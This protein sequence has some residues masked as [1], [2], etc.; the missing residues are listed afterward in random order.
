MTIGSRA[1]V[2]SPSAALIAELGRA[3]RRV[4]LE[5]RIDRVQAELERL[6]APK[7]ANSDAAALVG[8]LAALGL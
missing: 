6:S 8:Y 7:Q 5:A 4:E 1:T 2:C 3:K